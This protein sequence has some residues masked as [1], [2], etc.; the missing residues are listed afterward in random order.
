[1]NIDDIL[2][3]RQDGQNLADALSDDQLAQIGWDGATQYLTDLGSRSEWEIRY[4][5]ANK[6]ALQVQNIVT[7]GIF[8]AQLPKCFQMSIYRTSSQYAPARICHLHNPE[9]RK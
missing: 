2:K 5:E 3:T 4:R 8:R 9:T 6:L 1:M 7:A